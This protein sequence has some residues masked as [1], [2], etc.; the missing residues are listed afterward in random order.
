MRNAKVIDYFFICFLCNIS[1]TFET[2]CM[3]MIFVHYSYN[4]NAN[5]HVP[6]FTSRR[7]THHMHFV[8]FT[9]YLH[10]VISK[11]FTTLNVDFHSHCLII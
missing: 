4:S 3:I 11:V 8:I 10:K 7:Y 9:D 6:N 1:L 2:I 5:I